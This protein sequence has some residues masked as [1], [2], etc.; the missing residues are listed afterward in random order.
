LEYN[1]SPG[2]ALIDEADADILRLVADKGPLTLS[3]LAREL[4]WS[5]SMI[6]RRLR[7]L[8]SLG[9]V[10]LREVGGVVIVSTGQ[11]RTSSIAFVGI[12]RASE[13]PYVIP[14]LR[15][16]R[17]RFGHVEVRVYDDAFREALDLAAGRI[18][19][20]FAPAV[21]L[22]L[23]N[24]VTRGGVYIIGGGSRGGAAIIEGR[25]GEGHV[26]TRMSSMEL[27]AEEAHLEPPR[28][29]ASSGDEILG[30]VLKGRA[31]KGVVWEPYA[32]MA[33][34]AGLRVE[35]CEL[36]ACCLL[37]ANAQAE[38]LFDVIRRAAADSI[39]EADRVD[40]QAYASLVNM[41]Y[42]LVR[43]SVRSYEFLESP[44][45]AV[46]RRLIGGVR[47]VVMPDSVVNEAVR[48]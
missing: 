10:S 15:R 48:D 16:L 4:G 34:R 23:M 39:A 12:L 11:Q 47:N 13:Y 28:V 25:Q 30:S 5:K 42:E 35:P 1:C 9:L 3:E 43:D 19:L 41:P 18:Q 40:L 32:S 21:S 17:D 45:R 37:G 26:T 27:C 33:R 29:Y 8:A 2:R 22:L 24:R 46:L 14:F 6:H 38:G 36:E 31:A 20:A 7:R 44:D